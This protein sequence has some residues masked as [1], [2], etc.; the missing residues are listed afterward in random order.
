MHTN[1]GQT[2]SPGHW[3]AYYP[4]SS[5][6]LPAEPLPTFPGQT[7][8]RWESG[9]GV[10]KDFVESQNPGLCIS[11][12]FLQLTGF[13]YPRKSSV[14]EKKG[15]PPSSG[16]IT[17]KA[18]YWPCIP[19]PQGL[20]SYHAGRMSKFS[21]SEQPKPLGENWDFLVLVP[22]HTKMEVWSAIDHKAFRVLLCWEMNVGEER[23]VLTETEV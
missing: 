17:K 8:L 23:Y 1:G 21:G 10:P 22:K 12:S 18:D 16:E 3:R 4:S 14:V 5:L 2:Q 7:A 13:G 15:M 6:S 19:Q 11:E 9:A 20:P